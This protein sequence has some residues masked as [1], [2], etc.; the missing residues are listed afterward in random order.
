M[1]FLHHSLV[2]TLKHTVEEL[3][4]NAKPEISNSTAKGFSVAGDSYSVSQKISYLH[5]SKG[6]I[7]TFTKEYHWPLPPTTVK[8][9]TKGV[10]DNPFV[11]NDIETVCQQCNSTLQALKPVYSLLC[12]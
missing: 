1:Y 9:R 8:H 5:G 12:Y 10:P 2:L 4:G 6:C 7:T 3:I 11:Q